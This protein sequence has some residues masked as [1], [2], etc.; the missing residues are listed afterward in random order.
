M[1]SAAR[2]VHFGGFLEELMMARDARGPVGR[3]GRRIPEGGLDVVG[4][5]HG[6][7]APDVA[8]DENEDGQA[9]FPGDTRGFFGDERGPLRGCGIRSSS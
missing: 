3:L 5:D 8:A 2:H 4:D 6:A 7:A 9:D 1:P